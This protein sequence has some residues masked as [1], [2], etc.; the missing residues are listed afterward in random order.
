MQYEKTIK[1]YEEAK[2][3]G[4]SSR[5][6]LLALMMEG[7][8]D[9]EKMW[10]TAQADP[11]GFLYGMPVFFSPKSVKESR[12]QTEK[13]D[14]LMERVNESIKEF[15]QSDAILCLANEYGMASEEQ[16]FRHGF[17]L[18]MKLCVG[19]MSGGAC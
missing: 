5:E 10:E 11:L 18:A 16:G 14:S 17:T 9:K 1:E 6:T 3:L 19:A 12:E 7:E 2:G 4:K 8:N 15:S 13:F